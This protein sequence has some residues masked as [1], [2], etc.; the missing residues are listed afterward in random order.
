MG[1]GRG[2]ERESA[3]Y[4]NT[5]SLR[6]FN[7]MQVQIV[8]HGGLIIQSTSFKAKTKLPQ[9]PQLELKDRKGLGE[10][11]RLPYQFLWLYQARCSSFTSHGVSLSPEAVQTWHFICLPNTEHRK[12]KPFLNHRLV[13]ELGKRPLIG[14]AC[15]LQS[16]EERSLGEW[17]VTGASSPAKSCFL[18]RLYCV[19]LQR[20]LVSI[21]KAA[22]NV[23]KGRLLGTLNTTLIFL[24]KFTIGG[25]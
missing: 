10:E 9:K 24:I 11:L 14:S 1:G 25:R 13:T 16:A 15:L 6:V 19:P 17:R 20:T 22:W 2:G 23:W 5:Y 8:I 3:I 12:A 21:E 18:F 7:A 4:E